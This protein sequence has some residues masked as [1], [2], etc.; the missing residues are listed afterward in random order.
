M[1]PFI[2]IKNATRDNHHTRAIEIGIEKLN[3]D[4]EEEKENLK[5]ELAIIDKIHCQIGNLTPDLNTRRAK[6]Y[7]T[8]MER[9][10]EQFSGD[11]FSEFYN[12][13]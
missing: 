8:M 11:V 10:R 2:E 4:S 6:V 9:A 3:F 1:T 12:S 7:N 5:T 13:F